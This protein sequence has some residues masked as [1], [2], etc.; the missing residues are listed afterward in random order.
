[1]SMTNEL[2]RYAFTGSRGPLSR[3]QQGMIERAIDALPKPSVIVT[4]A[5]LGVDSYVARYAVLTGHKV[6]T[7]VPGN[8]ALVDPEWRSWCHTFTEMPPDSTY[9]DR[10]VEL[11]SQGPD[12]LRGFPTAPENYAESKRSGTWQTIRLGYDAC[13]TVYVCILGPRF[14]PR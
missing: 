2:P 1:M 5:C 13:S 11:V 12:G 3:E 7:V 9:R 8:R 6:H 4:G 14:I 10:N